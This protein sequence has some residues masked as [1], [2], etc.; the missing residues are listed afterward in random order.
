MFVFVFFVCFPDVFAIILQPPYLTYDFVPG[1]QYD[2]SFKVQG[3]KN[4]ESQDVYV[5]VVGILNKSIAISP[6]NTRIDSGIWTE[7]IGTIKIPDE[8]EPGTHTNKIIIV[9]GAPAGGGAVGSVA[10]VELLLNVQVPYPGKYATISLVAD[11]IKLGQKQNFVISVNNLG[12]ELLNS[13][14]GD[15][16]I[17]DSKE[18]GVGLVK[19]NTISIASGSLDKLSAVWDSVGNPRG[20]Y[21]AR[22]KV[23][24][25]GILKEDQKRFKIGDLLME[26]VSTN[27]TKIKKGD[28]GKVYVTAQSFWNDLIFGVYSRV[29]FKD[30]QGQQFTFRSQEDSVEGF[31]IK[32]L[33][34]YVDSTN[35]NPGTYDARYTLFY[36]N[37]TAVYDST[38]SVVPRSFLYGIN[39]TQVLLIL[40]ILVLL[41]LVFINV[42]RLKKQNIKAQNKQ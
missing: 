40:V 5:Y 20:E 24:Y 41:I 26:I 28:I 7:F 3:S 36:S 39:L 9:Q 23:Y 10:G 13:V 27:S 38:I 18:V 17:L 1:A 15:I 34:I 31:A 22:A 29:E 4:E 37:K 2:F 11:N 14:S 25:D 33:L 8:L 35:I 12:K 16:E 21:T 19:T 32:N 42:R 6:T 30:S